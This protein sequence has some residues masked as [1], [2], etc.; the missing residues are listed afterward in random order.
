MDTDTFRKVYSQYRK[1]EAAT[2]SAQWDLWKKNSAQSINAIDV[3]TIKRQTWT[4]KQTIVPVD[5]LQSRKLY[6]KSVDD[7]NP[8]DSTFSVKPNEGTTRLFLDQW[9]QGLGLPTRED[10]VAIE[11]FK[12]ARKRDWLE[13]LK[14]LGTQ[15]RTSE[16]KLK[17]GNELIGLAKNLYGAVGSAIRMKKPSITPGS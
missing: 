9:R 6:P 1:S 8:L 17:E 16:F 13:E 14:A 12:Q 7:L 15:T 2:K 5:T 10:D 11:Q 3:A 4:V